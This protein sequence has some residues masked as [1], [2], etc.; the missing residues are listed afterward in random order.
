MPQA[1]TSERKGSQP[2]APT[3]AERPQRQQQQQRQEEARAA[4]SSSAA[5]AEAAAHK[6]GDTVVGRVVNATP[7]GARIVILGSGADA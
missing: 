1:S 3:A 2:E 6:P 4:A 5:G 7:K